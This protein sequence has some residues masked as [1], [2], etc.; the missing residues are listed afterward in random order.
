M[1]H[2]LTI[3]IMLVSGTISAQAYNCG[4]FGIITDDYHNDYV[5][6][7]DTMMETVTLESSNTCEFITA[8]IEV[9]DI[10][11]GKRWTKL[12]VLIKHEDFDDVGYKI[13]YPTGSWSIR[14]LNANVP[15][16]NPW[17]PVP[18]VN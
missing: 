2:L 4:L 5:G 3:G 16:S 6:R 13:K 7:F 14:R 10:R 15:D 18:P 11:N 12:W 9:V 17:W 1:R 8:P